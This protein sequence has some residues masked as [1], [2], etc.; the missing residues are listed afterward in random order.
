M[1]HSKAYCCRRSTTMRNIS[2]PSFLS[3]VVAASVCATSRSRASSMMDMLVVYR[4]NFSAPDSKSCGCDRRRNKK[5]RKTCLGKRGPVF[6]FFLSVSFQQTESK[7]RVLSCTDV[8]VVG[9]SI[10]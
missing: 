6:F 8:V 1:R 9:G 4:Q 10:Q 5:C 3:S 2:P 7:T